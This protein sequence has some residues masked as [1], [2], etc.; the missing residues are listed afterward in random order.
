[1]IARFVSRRPAALLASLL[2]VVTLSLP[3][4][5]RAQVDIQSVTSPGGIEAWLVEDTSIPFVAIDLWFAGGGS[6][7]LPEAR[8]ATHLMAY[9]LEEGAGDRDAVAFASE[10]EGLAA[11]FDIDIY[12]DEIVIS[13]QMLT[14]NRDDVV[15]LLRDALVEPRFDDA[16]VERVRGQVLAGIESDL[17]D[18]D[19]IASTTFNTLAY[20]A[21][22][23]YGSALEGTIESVT[24]LTRDD[25]IAAH[26]AALVRD[27]V[28]VGVSGDMTPED[29]GPL[30]DALLGDLP[31]SSDRPLAEPV[32]V[33]LEA[34]VTV[35]DFPTPQ[36]SVIFGQH[37]IERDDPD[38]FPA[39]VMDTV[40]GAGGYRSR[41]MNEVREE[42]GLTY[43]ISTWLGLSRAAAMM[44]GGFSSSNDLVAEA[45]EVVQAEWAD[46]AANGITQEELDAVQRYLTGAYFMRFDGNSQIAGIMAAM[47]SDGM[48]I[49]Y[50]NTRNE[51]VMAVTVD[52]IRRVAARLVDPSALRFVVVGQPEGLT[53]SN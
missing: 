30:L 45:V 5:A 6:V 36:S 49:D 4:Q 38:F 29:L 31:A 52:D 24:A 26:R 53:A 12:R 35:I 8:G 32:D 15:A 13:I 22:H 39:F 37:G 42:R 19:T 18:P 47:Q 44:Q 2:A 21:D 25:L 7:D 16:S 23:P 28:A 17:V 34:G 48:P 14:Q 40:M 41:L 9:L 50:I 51:R 11:S 27:R 1:M 46:L 10:L 33:A 20:G 43:G 3:L